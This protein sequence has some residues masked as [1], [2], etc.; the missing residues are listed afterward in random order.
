MLLLEVLELPTTLCKVFGLRSTLR[1]MSSVLVVFNPKGSY[2]STCIV[3]CRVS[4][5]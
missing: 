1:R 5:L 2:I 3:E 4:I